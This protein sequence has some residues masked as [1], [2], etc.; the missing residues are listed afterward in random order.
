MRAFRITTRVAAMAACPMA[1]P[2]AD[3]SDFVRM[4]GRFE[5]RLMMRLPVDRGDAWR[6]RNR[7]NA[8]VKRQDRQRVP[9]ERGSP[10]ATAGASSPGHC[11]T[12]PNTV[13][14]GTAC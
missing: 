14:E 11:G 1:S 9:D 5:L 6:A 10:R 4:E 7:A 3:V 2:A 13:G 8:T 12:L